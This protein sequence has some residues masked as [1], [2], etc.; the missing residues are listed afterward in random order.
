MAYHRD[1]RGF[2]APNVCPLEHGLRRYQ[3]EPVHHDPEAKPIMKPFMSPIINDGF[4][5][6]RTSANERNAVAK[7]VVEV[8]PKELKMT[9]FL[10]RNMD[11]FLRHLIPEPG[12]LQPALHEDVWERQARPTQRALLDKAEGVQPHREVKAF[13]KA[14]AYQNVKP[15]RII[16]TINSSDKRDYSCYTYS[17]EQLVKKCEWYAFSKTPRGIAT[18]VAEVCMKAQRAAN[19]DYSKFD[20]HGSNLMRL[21]ELQAF[22]RA[23]PP[24]H[25]ERLRELHG[26]QYGIPGRMSYG[27]KFDTAYMRTSGSPDTS[28]F[29]SL[30]N[31]F[32]AFMAFNCQG[33]PLEECWEKLGIYGGDDGLTADIAP[34]HYIR[35]AAM[36]GQEL[37]FEPV[38]RGSWG[39]KFL[40]RY[41][42]PSVW[43]G[44]LDS[45][46][47]VKRQLS[48]FHL[49]VALPDTVKATD[50]LLEKVRSYSLS[51]WN[52]P[53][54]GDFL[55]RVVDIAGDIKEN[56]ALAVIRPWSY[57]EGD[58]QYPNAGGEW[59]HEV[60]LHT[61]PDADWVTF[62]K[63]LDG[64][65]T[66]E[67]LLSPPELQEQSAAKSAGV[68]V[69]VDDDVI[70]EEN[71]ER[72][73]PLPEK[74]K[75][76]K[77]AK[78]RMVTRADGSQETFEAFKQRKINRG[79]WVERPPGPARK[80]RQP[81][82]KADR[83]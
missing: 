67:D 78:P 81:R 18:R 14:E 54:I 57:Y 60:I 52:T 70:G 32:I 15:P 43:Y 69:V 82:N 30:F 3:F 13:M 2:V 49:T 17:F 50:K 20:G 21:F 73:A 51:D 31:A 19:T 25:H 83:R 74:K 66:L 37:T 29:N 26:S 9:K 23:F 64:V 48:K 1:V 42:S 33:T 16:A 22:M 40:A 44:E 68:P 35:A 65:S 7:R 36:V 77:D 46:C 27:T 55:R 72:K 76:R 34:R 75:E 41:Y 6:D 56:K 39:I 61:L 80:E 5:P 63:W 28:I 4:A 59:M 12:V 10:Q 24:E 62:G 8:R 58:E 38:E 71:R 79:E 11:A 47:D 45:M 53:G